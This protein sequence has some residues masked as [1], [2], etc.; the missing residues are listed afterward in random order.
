MPSRDLP[1]DI[2]YIVVDV[3]THDWKGGGPRNG[4]IGKRDKK[5]E[6]KTTS[7]LFMG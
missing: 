4:R 1:T 7:A 2:K 3:E 5:E 6:T